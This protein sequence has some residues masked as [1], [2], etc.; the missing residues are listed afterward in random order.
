MVAVKSH[1]RPAYFSR[2]SNPVLTFLRLCGG[3]H[4][5]DVPLA[6]LLQ[7]CVVSV[8][9]VNTRAVL[10]CITVMCL[11]ISCPQHSL[12]ILQSST[13]FNGY[14]HESQ[15]PEL[16]SIDYKIL[17]ETAGYISA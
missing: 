7:A 16:P 6:L 14:A 12:Q 4:A 10:S 2:H 5:M 9:I 13:L 1:R 3:K 8:S 17:A 15:S 11:T